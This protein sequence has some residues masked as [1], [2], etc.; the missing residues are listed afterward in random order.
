VTATGNG[1]AP[2]TVLTP[3]PWVRRY[4][5]TGPTRMRL[6]C[7]P[8]AGGGGTVFTGWIPL[9]RTGVELV[10][11]VL[12]G[13]ETRIHE[14]PTDDRAGLVADITAALDF[15]DGVPL[16][17]Y[18]HSLGAALM[19][20]VARRAQHL[21]RP[22]VA[23]LIVS[24]FH[25]PHHPSEL[26]PL[27]HLPRAELVAAL[28]RLGGLH[29]EVLAHDDFL[30]IVLRAVRADLRLAE[31]YMCL[32]GPRLTCPITVLAG[33]RDPMTTAQNLEGWGD[34]TVG[35]C[36]RVTFDGDHF[37]FLSQSAAVVDTINRLLAVHLTV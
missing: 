27:S 23:H 18:G 26:P 29:P 30:D 19:F 3:S 34:Y 10:A 37:F 35:R 28:T 12:P 2:Y 20:E 33:T 36:E 17:L 24:G 25:A 16:A 4:M 22:D 9:L 5:P 31:E 7:L 14:T 15:D 6:A 13:R 32:P 1:R 21:R 11:V 8:H